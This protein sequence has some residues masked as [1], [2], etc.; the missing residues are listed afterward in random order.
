LRC[1]ETLDPFQ[2]AVAMSHVE[3][4]QNVK[5]DP[6]IKVTYWF[7]TVGSVADSH[8]RFSVSRA[9]HLMRGGRVTKA[10]GS[11]SIAGLAMAR[12]GRS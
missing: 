10:T 8:P 6:V 3:V 2:G 9:T 5:P 11:L 12:V 7:A 1:G 4:Q